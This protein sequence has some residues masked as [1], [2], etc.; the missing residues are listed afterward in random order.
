MPQGRSRHRHGG[1]DDGRERTRHRRKRRRNHTRHQASGSRSQ[2]GEGAGSGGSSK[3]FD[4]RSDRERRR[5]RERHRR[6]RHRSESPSH[7]SHSRGGRRRSHSPDD[8]GRQHS[9]SP[10]CE[11]NRHR[12]RRDR[13]NGPSHI[14]WKPGLALGE[15]GR[16]VVEKL[17]GDGASGRVLGC[18]DTRTNDLV[19]VKVAK[20]ARRQRRHAETEIETLQKL[21]EHDPVA[22]RKHVVRLLDNFDHDGDHTCI[23]FEPLAMSLRNL[24]E[25]C[26]RCG[27]YLADIR[28][29]AHQM[30]SCL[31]FFHSMGLA[32]G[33]LKCTNVMLR[34][35]KFELQPHPRPQ[36]PDEV[37]ARPH[38]PFEVVVIDYGL[39]TLV[40]SETG[41]GKKGLRVGAR[42]IRAPEV[43][44]GLDWGCQADL[45]SLGCLLATLYTGDRLFP[46]HDEMEHLA[47]IEQVIETQIP[48]N[49]SNRVAERILQKGVA[50]E[51]SGRLAWP[52]CARD[53]R[54]VRRVAN[55]LP[56]SELIEE[57]HGEFLDLMRGLL[58]IDPERRLTAADVLEHAFVCKDLLTAQGGDE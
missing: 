2:S 52:A 23:V 51:P 39:A 55:L 28:S 33:D 25:E 6:R 8:N 34:D 19:A 45:W 40:D 5:R 12:G 3:A 58:E 30:A 56:L 29:V 46:V 57:R 31:F 14:D 47:A 18:R 50:F 20:G 48:T 17:F 54:Q 24:L 10:E 44:L 37:A 26:G 42:H 35:G 21:K 41:K 1:G 4:E 32:H 27:L 7:R 9:R 38:W 13:D 43:I 11:Q 49:M 15:Q 22:S 16:Y 53:E 36:D